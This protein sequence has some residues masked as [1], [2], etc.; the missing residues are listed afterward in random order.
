MKID[1]RYNSLQ[2]EE[3]V[4]FIARSNSVFLGQEEYI[5]DSIITSMKNLAF[6]L[7]SSWTATMGYLLL[8]IDREL[9]GIDED[10]NSVY[11]EIY[12]DPSVS[13]KTYSG[14]EMVEETISGELE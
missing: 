14:E 8:V 3:A 4:R 1:L 10:C 6:K 7:D 5:R 13:K 12:V 11:I 9:E 2:L